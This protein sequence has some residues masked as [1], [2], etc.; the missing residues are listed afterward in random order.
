MPEAVVDASAVLRVLNGEPGA[1]DVVGYLDG[2]LVSAVN[3]AEV[4]GK[5]VDVGMPPRFAADL[6][7]PLRLQVVAFDDAQAVEAAA[8]RGVPRGRALSL[9]DRA[10]L[11]LAGLR[12]LPAVTADA[13]WQ[14]VD[15]GVD[16]IVAR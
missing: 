1:A 5:L 14:N 10:C 12:S 7:V 13:A 6:C 15:L 11:A 2:A 3:Y 8:L 4:V 16:V 9:G